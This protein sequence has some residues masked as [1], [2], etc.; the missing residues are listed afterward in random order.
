VRVYKLYYLVAD[1]Q[2][3]ADGHQATHTRRQIITA[4]DEEDE[5]GDGG[6]REG[7]QSAGWYTVVGYGDR[8]A[9]NEA[10]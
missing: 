3:M 10:K 4:L 8:F 5:E 2:G 1:M 7:C 6:G 9:G